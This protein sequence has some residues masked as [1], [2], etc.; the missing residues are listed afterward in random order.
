M[1]KHYLL[2]LF[3][4]VMLLAIALT[5][6]VACDAESLKVTFMLDEQEVYKVVDLESGDEVK[7]PEEPTKDG[8]VFDGWYLDKG[9]WEKQ[10]FGKIED[11][12]VLAIVVYVK[13]TE[14]VPSENPPSGDL[15]SDKCKHE[16][17]SAIELS[18]DGCNHKYL[19]VCSD[20][21]IVTGS[22][23]VVEH[24]W[25]EEPIDF[26]RESCLVGAHTAI[27]CVKCG[28]K[29]A[30]T[31]VYKSID[32]DGLCYDEHK[33]VK[34]VTY[35]DNEYECVSQTITA[36]ICT[37][38]DCID[39]FIETINI[40]EAPG[41]DWSDWKVANG[42]DMA[43]GVT[44]GILVRTC[45]LCTNKAA[46]LKTTDYKRIIP[47]LKLHKK[48]ADGNDVIENGKPVATV[49]NNPWYTYTKGTGKSCSTDGRDDEYSFTAPDGKT[50]VIKLN[51]RTNHYLVVDGEKKY[52]EV[53]NVYCTADF[54][55]GQLKVLGGS[56]RETCRSAGTDGYYVCAECD[57]CISIFVRKAHETYDE[58]KHTLLDDKRDATCKYSGYF[59]YTCSVC[60]EMACAVLP[61]LG[62]EWVCDSATA[63]VDGEL[64]LNVSCNR[65]SENKAITATA[66]E[67][68]VAPACTKA[69]YKGYTNITTKDGVVLADIVDGIERPLV[70]KTETIPA[71]GHNHKTLGRLTSADLEKAFDI[72]ETKYQDAFKLILTT[73]VREVTCGS[74]A[75]NA[76]GGY[77]IC[78][79]CGQSVKVSLYKSHT[80][81]AKVVEGNG[82]R[83]ATC[84]EAGQMTIDGTCTDCGKS[85]TVIIPALGHIKVYTY[86]YDEES[87]KWTVS[88][89]CEREGCSN[90]GKLENIKDVE[91]TSK[92][93]CNK[94]G[95]AVVSFTD[96]TDDKVIALTKT[97]HTLGD[98]EM[99]LCYQTEF[100]VSANDE[101][102]LY[103]NGKV[104][105]NYEK[106]SNINLLVEVNDLKCSYADFE[107][108]TVVN[109]Y[110]TCAVCSAQYQIYVG[111]D[112]VLKYDTTEGSN[113]AA[114]CTEVGNIKATCKNCNYAIDELIAPL[115]H[116]VV[117]T[118]ADGKVKFTCKR[119]GCNAEAIE[120][121]IPSYGDVFKSVDGV[122]VA[123][124]N[125]VWKVELISSNAATCT[126]SATYKLTLKKSALESLIGDDNKNA[127]IDAGIVVA[128]E[129]TKSADHDVAGQQEISW[130]SNGCYYVGH[131]CK[132]C[133][134]V[135]PND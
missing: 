10:F 66:E 65:C 98:R 114:T 17:T 21:G 18:V 63:V 84:T 37:D 36:K 15:P 79:E 121:D 26:K 118:M 56:S 101:A 135:I 19:L 24:T 128:I 25:S 87:E 46:D 12:T 73:T 32:E 90:C 70:V 115:G 35:L 111:K 58:E 68:N 28:A 133:G 43:D 127:W 6:L 100:T 91:V 42:A 7:L 96:G 55:D 108:L 48:D 103:S 29:N 129:V 47:S 85:G 110:F 5:A 20:C 92:S 88:W 113:K 119:A 30:D 106:L 50:V 13:W 23:T 8:F 64:T 94:N 109:A 38:P 39:N 99:I 2:K 3:A 49:G 16:N 67:L 130:T 89:H 116:D 59:S 86:N 71:L 1:K 102:I 54:E 93:T 22:Q 131:I 104:V 44:E 80:G 120:K 126:T 107:N 122:L 33:S 34:E 125:D 82:D 40:V 134:N 117:V 83:A 105:Y 72:R 57:Y 81:E 52:L 69:G 75:E 60:G 11:P 53:G 97:C 61:E 27:Y 74:T 132:K 14:G 78:T 76:V 112:H 77:F 4:T 9:T 123:T 31:I 41:H 95:S 51:V 62:H 45:S 124:S